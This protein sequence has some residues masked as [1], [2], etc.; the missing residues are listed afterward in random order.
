MTKKITIAVELIEPQMM[1][2][3]QWTSRA[4]GATE[5]FVGAITELQPQKIS[6][7]FCG[8]PKKLELMPQVEQLLQEGKS[9]RAIAAELH[10]STTTVQTVKKLLP[11]TNNYRK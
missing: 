6:V 10:I 9:I 4:S 7:K 2:S 8:R 3:E 5:N 1:P 11:T